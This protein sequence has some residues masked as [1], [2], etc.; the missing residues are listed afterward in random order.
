MANVQTYEVDDNQWIRDHDILF[1][2]RFSTD[3]QLVIGQFLGI[4][5]D[6]NEIRIYYG[7]NKNS[8][9]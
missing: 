6:T 1:T 5:K 7:D 8:F 9:T 4:T 3:E 2:N